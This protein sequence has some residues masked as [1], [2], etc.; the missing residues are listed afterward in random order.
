MEITKTFIEDLY[1]IEY[2]EY[3]D[4]RGE[5]YKPYSKKIFSEKGIKNLDF[6][7]TWFTKSKKNVIRGM[8]YQ[9]GEMECE[10][11]VSCI[12]GEV[13]DVIIDLRENSLTYGEKFSIYMNE[14]EKKAIYIPVGCAHGY[15]VMTEESIVLYMATEI[16]S[17]KDD[18]GVRWNS[19]NFKWGIDNPILSERDKKLP[20]FSG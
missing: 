8:H 5:L 1:L 7:E 15:R 9:G 19:I 18:V 4:L 6:K 2:S 11:L 14:D 3:K 17:S 12:K 16:H 13:L 20:K 10:K